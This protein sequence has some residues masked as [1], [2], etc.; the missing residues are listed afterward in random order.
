MAKRPQQDRR[1]HED[2]GIFESDDPDLPDGV[3]KWRLTRIVPSM[4]I[5]RGASDERSSSMAFFTKDARMYF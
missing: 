1:V 3:E 5:F 4:T 2:G